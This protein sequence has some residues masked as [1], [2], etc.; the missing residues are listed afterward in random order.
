MVIASA[1]HV[2]EICE[3]PR[4]SGSSN[5]A[6]RMPKHLSV[7]VERRSAAQ[8]AGGHADTHRQCGRGDPLMPPKRS[9][10]A[11]V[12]LMQFLPFAD[13][14]ALALYDGFEAHP[15]QPMR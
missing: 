13:P 11:G 3:G 5:E 15:H 6:D 1:G 2:I 14:K 9:N 12:I 7:L 8:A 10:V 4:P